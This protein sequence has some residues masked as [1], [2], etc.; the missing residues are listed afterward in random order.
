MRKLRIKMRMEK[1]E[2]KMVK[3]KEEEHFPYY[4]E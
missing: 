4:L 1:E 2:K 3:N